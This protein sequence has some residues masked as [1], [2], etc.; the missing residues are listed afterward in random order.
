MTRHALAVLA[1]APVYLA[2]AAT[3]TVTVPSAT[4]IEVNTIPT[5]VDLGPDYYEDQDWFQQEFGT[6]SL[7]TYR[8]TPPASVVEVL[9]TSYKTPATSTIYSET[10]STS[11]PAT[12]T[13]TV[14]ETPAS[15]TV[16]ETSWTTTQPATSTVTALV[17]AATGTAA[18]LDYRLV[19]PASCCPSAYVKLNKIGRRQVDLESDT[20]VTVTEGTLYTTFVAY[21]TEYA[22]RP[23]VPVSSIVYA[24]QATVTAPRPT[25]TS[26]S[27]IVS[28][29]A[30]PV[31]TVP[32]V[33]VVVADEPVVTKTATAQ[34][35]TQT[36]TVTSTTT[37]ATPVTTTTSTLNAQATACAQKTVWTQ[38][39]CPASVLV[40]NLVQDVQVAKL[41]LYKA[42]GGKSVVVDCG[43]AGTFRY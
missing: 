32:S 22:P 38:N 27:T 3:V 9:T 14:N 29:A 40:K 15:S 20:T 25:I 1:L 13:V 7:G 18:C 16:Y 34:A 4:D 11:T 8:E 39:A 5:E 43:S 28:E 37:L 6:I 41:N 19:F 12:R 42:L 21:E 35:S 17:T 36:V 30:T 10:V 31:V 24:Y 2:L 26:T 33:R 23:E